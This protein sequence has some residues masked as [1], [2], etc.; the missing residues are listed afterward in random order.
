MELFVMSLHVCEHC[1]VTGL[2][3]GQ[4]DDEDTASV[5]TLLGKTK[6]SDLIHTSQ[7]VVSVVSC[8]QFVLCS[9]GA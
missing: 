4:N 9:S 3:E 7:L 8:L 1:S 2:A 6:T 5:A